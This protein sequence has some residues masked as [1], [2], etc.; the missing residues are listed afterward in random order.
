MPAG[1]P[2][3]P[4]TPRLSVPAAAAPLRAGSRKRGLARRIERFSTRLS[5]VAL[6][7][8]LA[9]ALTLPSSPPPQARFDQRL[10]TTEP[11]PVRRVQLQPVAVPAAVRPLQ[12]AAVDKPVKPADAK[13]KPADQKPADN[14]PLPVP[15]AAAPSEQQPSEWKPE[16]VAEAKALCDATLKAVK[17]T[18]EQSPP[19]RNGACGTPA[20]LAV[21]R[22]GRSDVE[23]QPAA[24]VNCR[25]AVALDKWIA[26]TLQPS[27][28]KA[29]AS[30]VARI[31]VAASY[32]CRNRY[33]AAQ[34]PIS[35]HAFANALDMTGVVLADGRVI[36]VLDGWGWTVREQVAAKDAAKDAA[37]PGGAAAGKMTEKAPES[38][39]RSQPK[40]KRGAQAASLPI[41]VSAPPASD[42]PG[43]DAAA[44]LRELHAGACPVF[45]TV[46]GPEA[47][48]AH[49]DH[50]HVDMK[51]RT[52]AHICQ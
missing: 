22:I 25:M 36:K 32:T 44:F 14:K 31:L 39:P 19:L 16:E 10:A 1:V 50:L 46:L 48:D 2:D 21:S 13:A 45:G 18:A 17:L 42:R 5:E 9:F 34:A 4:E 52:H 33:G 35:E 6:A 51:A 8:L 20:P 38:Q 41:P 43:G 27:A 49:R 29:F 12:V 47:N 30:P 23:L 15:P 26:D 7:G 11:F 40:Q 28:Q 37:K 24:I 3:Q